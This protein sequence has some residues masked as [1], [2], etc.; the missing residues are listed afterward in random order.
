[1]DANLTRL[2]TINHDWRVIYQVA[3]AL[4]G[5]ILL[6]AFFSFPETAYSRQAKAD[7]DRIPTSIDLEKPG[8][9]G[10]EATRSA[11]SMPRKESY[12]QSLK[13]FHKTQ[14][15]ES[16]AKLF[17]RPL[18]LIILPSVLWAAL[19]QAATI[20]FLVAVSSNVAPAYKSAYGFEAYQVGLCFIAS[21]VGSLLGIPA[22]GHFGDAVADFF[23]RRNKGVREPEMRLP[24]MVLSL[25]TTPLALVLFGVG[26]HHKLHWMCPT[27]GLGLCRLLSPQIRRRR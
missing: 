24:A 6:V 4:V 20:G 8:S 1:L 21:I 16:L 15:K 14:T 27:I 19:V 11:S 22:G 2:I 3:S 13:I 12:I 10:S 7:P 25:V 5:L 23:T 18:G 17:F 26:I 9:A